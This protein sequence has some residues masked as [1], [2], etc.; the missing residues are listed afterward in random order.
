MPGMSDNARVRQAE[1]GAQSD[2]V[3]LK[4]IAMLPFHGIDQMC[5]CTVPSGFLIKTEA[6]CA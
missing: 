4:T 3:D 1:K 5:H 6:A 2:F